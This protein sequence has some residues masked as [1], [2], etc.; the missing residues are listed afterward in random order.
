MTRNSEE[1]IKKRR[2]YSSFINQVNNIKTI[3]L[4]F[5]VSFFFKYKVLQKCRIARKIDCFDVAGRHDHGVTSM[6]CVPT[7]GRADYVYYE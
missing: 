2:K 6:P 1:P 7:E 3:S 4:K 5:T